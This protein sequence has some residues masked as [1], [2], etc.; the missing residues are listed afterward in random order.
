MNTFDEIID[1]ATHD[2]VQ[3]H[4]FTDVESAEYKTVFEGRRDTLISDFNDKVDLNNITAPILNRI[5]D[6]V[7]RG[8]IK[9]TKQTAVVSLSNIRGQGFLDFIQFV[10]NNP[11]LEYFQLNNKSTVLVTKLSP[12]KALQMSE[13]LKNDIVYLTLSLKNLEKYFELIQNKVISISS[14]G[15]LYNKNKTYKISVRVAANVDSSEANRR[16]DHYADVMLRLA[17]GLREKGYD[18]YI[19]TS[20][21]NIGHSLTMYTDDIPSFNIFKLYRLS[22][23]TIGVRDDLKMVTDEEFVNVF[24]DLL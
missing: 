7:S 13:Y 6:M 1:S 16:R 21:G 8:E 5:K 23:I 19:G 9:D 4:G 3:S 22:N 15:K 17:K 18:P 12:F 2:L 20:G 24:K 11:E 14:D 10:K